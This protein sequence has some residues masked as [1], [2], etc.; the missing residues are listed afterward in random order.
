MLSS[1]SRSTRRRSGSGSNAACTEPRPG[2]RRSKSISD[3]KGDQ[4]RAEQRHRLEGRVQA[5]RRPPPCRS[6]CRS[7]GSACDCGGCTSSKAR[8]RRSPRSR[9]R[10]H[11]GRRH[12]SRCARR[13]SAS[14]CARSAS[15]RSRAARPAAGPRRAAGRIRRAGARSPR[16][17]CSCWSASR[18]RRRRTS[19]RPSGSKRLGSQGEPLESKYQRTASTP[20]SRII[21]QGSTTLPRRLLIL[22]PSLSRTRPLTAQALNAGP[23][24]SP[25][26]GSELT[27]QPI[28]CNV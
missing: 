17:T 10:R 21:A 16:R 11:R 26:S 22:T 19:S 9:G 6:P 12:P 25:A 24:G 3:R 23:S 18:S 1:S 4:R 8:R 20:C 28:A 15:G 7:C 5:W 13:R 27:K 14:A 2:D